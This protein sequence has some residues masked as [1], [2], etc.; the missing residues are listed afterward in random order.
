MSDGSCTLRIWVSYWEQGLAIFQKSP[1]IRLPCCLCFTLWLATELLPKL[2]CPSQT[3]AWS[4]NCLHCPADYWGQELVTD[5]ELIMRRQ[6]PREARKLYSPSSSPGVKSPETYR[7]RGMCPWC[8]GKWSFRNS[9]A[10]SLRTR[11]WNSALYTP[12]GTLRV[13]LSFFHFLSFTICK[14]EVRINTTWGVD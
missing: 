8:R 6:N 5:R 13:P 14:M 1:G 11:C 10:L 9:P 4:N 12:Q 3:L 2:M 7:P